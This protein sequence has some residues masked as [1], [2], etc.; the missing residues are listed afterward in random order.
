MFYVA[1]AL[2]AGAVDTESGSRGCTLTLKDDFGKFHPIVFDTKGDL[3][4]S[5]Q[6]ADEPTSWDV[7]LDDNQE[8]ILSCMPNYLK[9][10]NNKK[11]VQVKCQ[12][13]ELIGDSGKVKWTD[14]AC[15]LRPI[16]EVIVNV[17][18]CETGN[19]GIE[20]GLTNPVTKKTII[21]GEACYSPTIGAT[22]FVHSK[23]SPNSKKLEEGALKLE[24]E[25]YLRKPH[26]SGRLKIDMMKAWG[27]HI[28]SRKP[29]SIAL[30]TEK[31]TLE[32]NI[33]LLSLKRLAWNYAFVEDEFEAWEDLQH[34]IRN[35]VHKRNEVL[36][37]WSGYMDKLQTI[38]ENGNPEDW[39]LEP[40]ERFPVPK[41]LWIANKFS[42][43]DRTAFLV[44][45]KSEMTDK[46]LRDFTKLCESDCDKVEWLSDVFKTKYDKQVLC[47]D[48]SDFNNVGENHALSAWK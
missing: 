43:G 39:F 21:L 3:F 23:Y 30:T 11:S 38:S 8:A 6:Q 12:N 16:E 10:Q 9:N 15:E 7:N 37:Y 34:E 47:C 18:G 45:N 26:P 28:K 2:V 14:M 42:N 4:P 44:T 35:H 24:E 36:E 29:D 20:F 48:T 32:D 25:L 13:G 40:R 5:N 1:L 22:R 17:K 33:Q 31:F 19:N 41:Y 27:N 46:E